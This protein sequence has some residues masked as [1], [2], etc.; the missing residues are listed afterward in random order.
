MQVSSNLKIDPR[1]VAALLKLIPYNTTGISNKCV[2]I[3]E[4][5]GQKKVML[6]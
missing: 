2:N 4:N 3:S 1:L 5:T 6:K